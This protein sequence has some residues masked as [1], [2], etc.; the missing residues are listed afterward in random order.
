[1]ASS[2]CC[3]FVVVSIHTGMSDKKKIDKESLS[4]KVYFKQ[5]SS[6]SPFDPLNAEEI[7]RVKQICQE[8]PKFPTSRYR[9]ISIDLKEP[10]KHA[11]LT[12]KE[13]G[14]NTV[15]REAIVC[16]LDHF[17]ETTFEIQ[18]DLNIGYV[19]TWKKVLQMSQVT[20][21]VYFNPT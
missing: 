10:E 8:F 16:L 15:P 2:I 9:F 5:C 1:M 4:N 20:T 13:N 11:V 14:V 6:K 3:R 18:V 19:K 12:S 17:N 7:S 21:N